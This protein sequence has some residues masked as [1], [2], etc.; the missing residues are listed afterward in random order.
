MV[1][2]LLCWL[3]TLLRLTSP[4]FVLRGGF[5]RIYRPHTGINPE[6]ICD[7]SFKLDYDTARLP[8]RQRR[9]ARCP[10]VMAGD[11]TRR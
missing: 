9:E 10:S 8:Y 1:S 6:N 5:G 7:S 2:L 4:L 11:E 3:Q